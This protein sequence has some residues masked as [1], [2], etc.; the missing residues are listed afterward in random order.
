MVADNEPRYRLLDSTDAVVGSI[1]EQTDGSRALQEA[2]SE[3]EI[4]LEDDG[5]VR[6][7]ADTIFDGVVG[8]IPD[9]A[10]GTV[11]AG[12]VNLGRGL[13][14]DGSGQV[15]LDEDTSFTFTVSQDFNA[16][17]SISEGQSIRDDTGTSR[18]SVNAGDVGI[19]TADVGSFSTKPLFS[20][21][22]AVNSGERITDESNIDRVEFRSRGTLLEDESGR[23]I[24]EASQAFGN[25]IRAF[26]DSPF[27]LQDSEGKF[28]A[29][30]YFTSSTSPGTLSLDNAV[31]ELRDSRL[32]KSGGTT[33]FEP[34]RDQVPDTATVSL[35][36]GGTPSAVFVINN[37][38]T[39]A[40]ALIGTKGGFGTV[41]LLNDPFNEF[42]T[43][44]GN[45]GTVNVFFDG[46]EYVIENETGDEVTVSRWKIG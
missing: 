11:D 38:S 14:N 44:Q 28:I 35:A 46:T 25:K 41:A 8:E 27:I 1:Y 37:K 5:S 17:L 15:Q 13:E 19:S 26:A 2:M 3:N 23:G 20:A 36:D 6:V 30:S 12:T 24:F 43:T 31:L 16:G 21:G 40:M 7:N 32:T 9:S 4:V 42:S 10:L 39:G 34:Y 18:V 29:L 45:Q 33:E 22:L